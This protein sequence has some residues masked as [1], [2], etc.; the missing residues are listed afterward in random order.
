MMKIYLELRGEDETTRNFDVG[1]TDPK[2]SVATDYFY[3][4]FVVATC[5][6]C[7]TIDACVCA[8]S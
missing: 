3:I 4:S 5:K 1:I 2:S 6:V 8:V 7:D